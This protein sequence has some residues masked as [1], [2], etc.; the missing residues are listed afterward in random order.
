MLHAQHPAF[1]VIVVDGVA[2]HETEHPESRKINSYLDSRIPGYYKQILQD[3]YPDMC[4]SVIS[5]GSLTLR[6]T[7]IRDF[8]VKFYFSKIR[9][10]P[11]MLSF[12]ATTENIK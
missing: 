3:S 11:V 5:G 2:C 8:G 1:L 9:I 6:D 10:E 7:N 12:L 4:Q